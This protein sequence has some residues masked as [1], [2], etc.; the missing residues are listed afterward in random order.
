M[1]LGGFEINMTQ[2]SQ[3]KERR[4]IKHV[5]GGGITLICLIA[6][7]RLVKFS[8]VMEALE[9]FQWRYLALG[10]L[11][12]GFGY[13]VRIFRWSVMLSATGTPVEFKNCAAPFL[14]AIALNNVLPLRLG[15]VVRA[16]VFPYAMGVTKTAATTSLVVERLIDLVTLLA[17]LALGVLAIQTVEVPPALR[18]TAVILA[19]LGGMTLTVGFFFSGSFARLFYSLA[20]EQSESIKPSRLQQIF[21][22]VGGLFE[23][24]DVMSRPR[25]LGAMLGLS[26]LVW[27][28]ESGLFYFAL[29]G[30][31]L[32]ASPLMALLVMAIA[33]LSTLAPSSPGYVG[34]FHLAAFTAVTLIG[35][36]AAQ[37]GSYAI[38]VHLALWLP[39]TIVGALAIWSRPALFKAA[40]A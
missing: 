24:F 21:H 29:M 40:R 23:S 38:I 12:L 14:G 26:V 36:S 19:L 15:D 3:T 30:L 6:I 33:T 10:I 11:S 37:A 31:G 4:W 7:F 22:A 20:G 8:E 5:I 35:G 9:H 34:P 32:D 28:G 18:Q 39:T 25:V 2:K 16:L 1:P 13:A 17:C 27:V